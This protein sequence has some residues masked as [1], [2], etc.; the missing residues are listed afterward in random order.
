MVGKKTEKNDESKKSDDSKSTPQVN[1]V[2][3][4]GLTAATPTSRPI[5]TSHGGMIKQDP[6]VSGGSD[7]KS[8]EEKSE[9][10]ISMKPELKIKPVSGDTPEDDDKDEEKSVPKQDN[11]TDKPEPEESKAET[12]DEAKAEVKTEEEKPAEDKADTGDESAAIESLASSA[13]SG[14]QTAQETEEEK[15]RTEKITELAESKKYYVSIVEG[16]HKASYERLLV[17]LIL[18]LLLAGAGVYLAID[19]GYLDVGVNLPYDFISN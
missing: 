7:D 5:I 18:F 16:G 6:M 11:E 1:D 17:W 3:K 13:T 4:P 15:K 19:A 10:R 9:S 12:T 8:V 14:K 2:A